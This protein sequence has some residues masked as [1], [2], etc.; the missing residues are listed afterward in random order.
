M[1]QRCYVGVQ[2]GT[3][4]LKSRNPV[5]VFLDSIQIFFTYKYI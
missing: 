3:K 5:Y 1:L 4:L 2:L